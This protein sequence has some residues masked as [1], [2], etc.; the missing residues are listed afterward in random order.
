M[1]R[2]MPI[3]STSKHPYLS[4]STVL[5]KPRWDVVNAGHKE[6]G[7]GVTHVAEVAAIWGGGTAEEKPLSPIIQ[8]YWTSFIRSKNPNTHRKKDTPEWKVWGKSKSRLNFPNDPKK[9]GMK[10]IDSKHEKN[11][12]YFSSI[13]KTLGM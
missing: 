9:V 5:T 11:C 10:D 6:S 3:G 7:L 13:G 12:D 4:I 1:P 2:E 8:G